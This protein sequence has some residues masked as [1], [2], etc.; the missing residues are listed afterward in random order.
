LSLKRRR[1][2]ALASTLSPETVTALENLLD[3]VVPDFSILG[4]NKQ[5]AIKEILEGTKKDP[6][7]TKIRLH[8]IYTELKKLA[9]NGGLL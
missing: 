1:L 4:Y 2:G 9:D 3:A 7:M 6:L 5:R 8:L